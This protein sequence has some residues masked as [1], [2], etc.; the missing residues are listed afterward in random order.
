M[1]NLLL[2]LK[3]FTL[4]FINHFIAFAIIGMLLLV[5]VAAVNILSIV[6]ILLACMVPS[7]LLAIIQATFNAIERKLKKKNDSYRTSK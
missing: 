6:L 5:V 2:F 4:Q 3:E 7:F 1:R